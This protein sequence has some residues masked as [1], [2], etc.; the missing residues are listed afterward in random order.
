VRVYSTRGVSRECLFNKELEFVVVEMTVLYGTGRIGGPTWRKP[1]RSTRRRW[2]A[3]EVKRRVD[4]G[5][6][7]VF[8]DNTGSFP[9]LTTELTVGEATGARE[10]SERGSSSDESESNISLNGSTRAGG[11]ASTGA[12]RVAVSSDESESNI[13]SNG[14]TRAGGWASTGAVRVAVTES[15]FR[16]GLSDK[17]MSSGGDVKRGEALRLVRPRHARV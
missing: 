11:W 1:L 2:C 4:E 3:R 12:V 5:V 15:W 9:K 13:S 7:K 8:C 6:P 17:N 16:G 14:S 10:K